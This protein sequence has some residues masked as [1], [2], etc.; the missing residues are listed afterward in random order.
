MTL[1][2]PF[3]NE[4]SE[5]SKKKIRLL[6]RN[7]YYAANLI[8]VF[9]SVPLLTLGGKDPISNL[10]ISMVIY[11]H[12]CCCKAI[13]IGLTTRH[14]RKR[15]EEH[16]QKS[17]ENFCFLDYKDDILIKI[18]NASKHSCIAEHLVNN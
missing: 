16:F 2:I 1:K 7:T 14:L 10:S 3:I 13:Y 11:Q 17:V 8:I 4:S 6:I 12:S 5:M 18:L 9:T 15:I